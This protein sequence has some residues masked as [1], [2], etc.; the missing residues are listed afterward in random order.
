MATKILSSGV[1][2]AGNDGGN[3][4]IVFALSL[5][6]LL[7]GAGVALDY[8]NLVR[9]KSE[10]QGALDATVLA[11]AKAPFVEGHASGSWSKKKASDFYLANVK[12]GSVSEWNAIA[13]KS[14]STITASASFEQKNLFLGVI[15]RKKDRIT[16]RAGAEAKAHPATQRFRFTPGPAKG[17]FNKTVTLFGVFE[18]DGKDVIK[19]LWSMHYEY[20]PFSITQTSSSWVSVENAKSG[21]L[22]MDIDPLSKGFAQYAH[23]Q[24]NRTDQPEL[25]DYIRVDT[26]VLDKPIDMLSDIPCGEVVNFGWEDGGDGDYKDFT[27]S[28]EGKCEDDS[29]GLKYVRLIK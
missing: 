16:V 18:E 8:N 10:M 24:T 7:G 22:Q 19:P 12:K 20:L 6:V 27:F 1:G 23:Y 2:F 21:Y 17:W 26:K 29:A 15:G 25:I 14:S 9:T 11:A 4:A 5:V 3:V 28:L 13:G